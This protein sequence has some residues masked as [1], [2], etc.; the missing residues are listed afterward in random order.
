M[1]CSRYNLMVEEREKTQA[2]NIELKRTL[3]TF[4]ASL[5]DVNMCLE[6]MESWDIHQPIRRPSSPNM[7]EK[8][9]LT[10]E[11]PNRPYNP[12]S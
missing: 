4:T 3:K 8:H 12:L 6:Q 7:G 9:N 2:V 5:H 1:A 11:G 10:I